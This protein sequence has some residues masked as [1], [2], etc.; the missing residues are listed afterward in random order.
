MAQ[1]PSRRRREGRNAFDPQVSREERDM[2][3]PYMSSKS[4]YARSHAKDWNDGWKE[5]EVKYEMERHQKD[6]HVCPYC[7]Q[8][9]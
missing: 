7:G 1:T 4:W 6:N 2:I 5:A 9:M 8:D 3:N